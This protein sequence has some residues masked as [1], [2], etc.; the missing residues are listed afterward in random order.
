M[1]HL[2]IATYPT[3]MMTTLAAASCHLKMEGVVATYYFSMCIAVARYEIEA[4]S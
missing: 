3:R 4:G 2:V 1:M